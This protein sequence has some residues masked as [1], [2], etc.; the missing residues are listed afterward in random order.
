MTA[1][2][3]VSVQDFDLSF[4]PKENTPNY[5]S[6]RLFWNDIQKVLF[7]LPNLHYSDVRL[8]YFKKNVYVYSISAYTKYLRT[9]FVHNC[10]HNHKNLGS[11]YI[12]DRYLDGA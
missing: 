8:Y 12:V 1:S 4:L 5:V 9:I 7:Y 6:F 2:F 11:T 3:Q 10:N